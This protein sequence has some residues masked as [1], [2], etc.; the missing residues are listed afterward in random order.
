LA[1]GSGGPDVA[2]GLLSTPLDGWGL[3]IDFPAD[4]VRTRAQRRFIAGPENRLAVRALEDFLSDPDCPYNPLVLHGPPGT[5][6]S[7]LA[8][9]VCDTWKKARP[10]DVVQCVSAGEF[11]SAY[12]ESLERGAYATWRS[13]CLAATLVVLEDL[14]QLSGKHAAQRE[15]TRMIDA[16]L[17]AG[18]KLLVTSRFAPARLS[19]ISAGLASR[20]SAGL[21]VPVAL[22]AQDARRAIV[23]ILAAQR[24]LNIA[25]DAARLLAADLAATIPEI[26]GALYELQSHAGPRN[27]IGV[28]AVRLYL[29]GRAADRIPTLHG[30][31]AQTARYFAVKVADLRSSSR[32]QTVVVARGMAMYLARQ[33]TGG[34]LQ[35]IGAYFGGR[36]HT[37]VSHGCRK[38][39]A[40]L[41]SDP[42]TRHALAQLREAL[43]SPAS[44]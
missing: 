15:L 19:T 16:L 30:I 40:L 33:L 29:R 41:H 11:A 10:H 39:E 31:A 35:Y 32:R 26:S 5:G 6:K 13:N 3:A 20:L 21:C 34:S 17:D 37:T 43:G 2:N 18:G 9:G 22:P 12:V 38:T 1:F 36:D 27:T 24:E 28:D 14:S 44:R 4:G 25:A 8:R 7:H 42:A 23:D